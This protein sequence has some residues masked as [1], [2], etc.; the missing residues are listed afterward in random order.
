MLFLK[1]IHVKK[2]CIEAMLGNIASMLGNKESMLLYMASMQ[3]CKIV[4]H[5]YMAFVQMYKKSMW[6]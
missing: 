3:R 1:K 4:K 6:L 5:I 2:H